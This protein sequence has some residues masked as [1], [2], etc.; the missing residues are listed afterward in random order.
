RNIAAVSITPKAGPWTAPQ[1]FTGSE[2]SDTKQRHG[3]RLII[4]LTLHQSLCIRGLLKA[5]RQL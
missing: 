3:C 1:H 4:T 2:V 5:S